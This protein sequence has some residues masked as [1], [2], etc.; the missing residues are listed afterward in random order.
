MHPHSPPLASWDRALACSIL[1]LVRSSVPEC[2]IIILPWKSHI[3]MK[4]HIFSTP[5]LTKSHHES[6]LSNTSSQKVPFFSFL[7]C[8]IWLSYHTQLNSLCIKK[9]WPLLWLT[10]TLTQSS[11]VCPVCLELWELLWRAGWLS[12]HWSWEGADWAE[13]IPGCPGHWAH[14]VIF[15]KEGG[16]GEGG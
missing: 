11:P 12:S 1:R 10:P 9:P 6:L 2:N 4:I 15:C 5:C 8:N 16:W 7:K 3:F 13:V 14:W